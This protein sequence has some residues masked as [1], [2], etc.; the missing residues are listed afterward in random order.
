MMK[1]TQW[2]DARR[3]IRRRWVSWLS[4]IVIAML[5]AIAFL[6]ICYSV[7]SMRDSASAC[8]KG[9]DFTDI[10]LIGRGLLSAQDVEAV[11]GAEGVA[12]AEGVLS[13]PSRV[14]SGDECHDVVLRTG[15]AEIS[16]SE[17]RRVGKEC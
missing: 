3:T 14:S 17:E 13:V 1:K 9:Q 7:Q 10:E 8:Y 16:R 5:A 4:I 2:L 12:A 6:G 15:T 11:R